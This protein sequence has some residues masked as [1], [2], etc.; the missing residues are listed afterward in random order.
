MSKR[1]R[2]GARQPA[3]A[4]RGEPSDSE[5]RTGYTLGI[6]WKPFPPGLQSVKLGVTAL[7]ADSK[8]DWGQKAL[9]VAYAEQRRDQDAAP[10]KC[11]VIIR[12]ALAPLSFQK[13]GEVERFADGRVVENKVPGALVT[14]EPPQGA[15]GKR[16]TEP[17]R[18]VLVDRLLSTAE[19]VRNYLAFCARM[20]LSSA[21]VVSGSGF[22]APVR[23]E[24]PPERYAPPGPPESDEQRH[25][26]DGMFQATYERTAKLLERIPPDSPL[27][28]AVSLVGEAIWTVDPEER[29]FYAWRAVE[30]VANFD[31]SEVRRRL[32]N[33]DEAYAVGYLRR[34]VPRLLVSNELRLD[35]LL[36]VQ[37]SMAVRKP[38]LA[39]ETVVVYY[40]LRNAVAHGDVS[41]EQH[42]AITKA[43]G[44]ITSL[45]LDVV[46]RWTDEPPNPSG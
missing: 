23:M 38:D 3:P 24:C 7:M 35:A 6:A 39:P 37:A 4:P 26:W 36:K 41:A 34:G 14:Y 9:D 33:G 29:F 21:G 42:A 15:F 45:A 31:L 19:R 12:T 5:P 32:Q 44:E 28:R 22:L 43:S 27:G 16:F 18:T 10:N 1:R 13:V 40:E 25:A 11:R 8:V 30:V 17:D 46:N 20:P 2:D